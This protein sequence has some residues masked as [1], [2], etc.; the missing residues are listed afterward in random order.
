[1]LTTLILSA[2]VMLVL[3]IAMMVGVLM[4]REP[5]K[6]SCGGIGAGGQCPCGRTPGS[7]DQSPEGDRERISASE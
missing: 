4:G 5:I 2:A 6:G 1:M 7:C 3:F